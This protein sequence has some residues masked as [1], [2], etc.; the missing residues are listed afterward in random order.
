MSSGKRHFGKKK[1]DLKRSGEFNREVSRRG[2][3]KGPHVV[4][5]FFGRCA[6]NSAQCCTATLHN[7]NIVGALR[8]RHEHFGIA[9]MR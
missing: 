1:P 6:Q 3:R 4:V 7:G 8:V 5:P 2:G 9:A